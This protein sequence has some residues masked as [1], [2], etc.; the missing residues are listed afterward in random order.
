MAASASIASVPALP[1]ERFFR[2]S[3]FLLMTTAVATLV[4]TGKLDLVTMI[5][6][7][8][9]VLYVISMERSE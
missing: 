5:V 4:G 2:T 3:L 8:S 7:P 1:A 9:A 6:A